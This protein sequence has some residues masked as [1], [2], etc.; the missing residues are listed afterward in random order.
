MV[1][2]RRTCRGSGP[3]EGSRRM[4][5]VGWAFVAMTAY[6]VTAVLLKLALKDIPPGVAIVITNAVLV[7]AGVGLIIYRGE[8]FTDH[9][10]V[11]R[12]MLLAVPGGS[13]AQP[14]HRRLLHRAQPGADLRRRADLRHVRP[15]RHH[16]RVRPSRR[17]NQT[18]RSRRGN[19]G[20][21]SDL[22]ADAM[23]LA[24]GQKYAITCPRSSWHSCE[25]L[26]YSHSRAAT[27]LRSAWIK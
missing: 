2:S 1:Y 14:Q 6:G 26:G 7:L 8:S 17:G 4:S 3:R 22:L 10:E 21:R 12:P 15:S 13:H 20:G 11:S 16:H 25:R 19:P 18:H 24:A 5:Y 9:I 23:R 27:G